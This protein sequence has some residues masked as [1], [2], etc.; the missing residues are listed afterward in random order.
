M[1][2]SSQGKELLSIEVLY[3]LVREKGLIPADKLS[4]LLIEQDAEYERQSSYF[5]S[6]TFD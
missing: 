2:S 4:K 5:Q 1:S 6:I 3:D